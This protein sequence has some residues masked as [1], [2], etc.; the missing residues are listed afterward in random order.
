MRISARIMAENIKAN[1]NKQS[2]QLM[3]SQTKIATGKRIN[4]LSDDPSSMRKVLNYRTT[5]STIE[6]YQ[7]NIADA[8]TRV[9]YT[10]TVL[11]QI[12]D[13]VDQ[14]TTIASNPDTEN[15]E[16]LS[17]EIANM[18]DQIM[19][20][21]NTKYGNNY[22]FHGHLTD[23]PPFDETT[24]AYDNTM[25]GSDENHRTLI[26]DGIQVTFNADGSDIFIESGDNLFTI[27]DDLEA[28]LIADD[29][30]AIAATVN[31]L[32]RI[33]DQLETIRSGIASTYRRLESTDEHW[34]A[35][36]LSVE[37]MRSTVEDA[38][39]AEAAIDLQLQ[40]TSY[41]ML[42]KVAADVIQPTLVD[43]LG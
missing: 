29:D 30:T 42:L 14:A 10:E 26:G 17:Q 6:Q 20:L 24:G 7:Q 12:N 23:T 33:G 39:I 18:R 15:R 2:L 41:E 32:Y 40:Q 31:P 38:D 35:F 19:G 1:L 22:I 16:A 28:G 21:A 4:S 13:F 43:F 8:K 27:L 3:N 34:E 11:G 37:N 5:L 9:E 25:P 36:S